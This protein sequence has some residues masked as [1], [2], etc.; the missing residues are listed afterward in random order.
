[1]RRYKP[2]GRSP[3]EI[4]EVVI[5]TGRNGH[6]CLLDPA[7]PYWIR[8]PPEMELLG[9]SVSLGDRVEHTAQEHSSRRMPLSALPKWAKD[10][11]R[12]VLK[13][14]PRSSTDTGDSAADRE[15]GSCL[16]GLYVEITGECNLRC[17][18][19][20]N[21]SGRA[22]RE[23]EMPTETLKRVIVEATSLGASRITFSGGE[24][25]LR[26]DL[27]LLLEWAEECGISAFVVTNGTTISHE[28]ASMLDRFT[29]GVQVS[30]DGATARAHDA[31]RGK[32]AYRLMRHGLD[33]LLDRG[34]GP[35]LKLATC[36]TRENLDELGDIANMALELGIPHVAFIPLHRQ[37]R[38]IA[39]WE[40]LALKPKN[41]VRAAK[42]LLS[43]S[44]QLQGQLFVENPWVTGVVR[45]LLLGGRA[46]SF[47]CTVGREPRI[48]SKGQVYP[49]AF[50]D[51]REYVMGNVI[52][53][54]LV[55]A[56][57]SPLVAEL[58]RA[59]ELRPALVCG[60]EGRMCDWREYCGGGCM[61]S[62]Y[63]TYG[64]IW[65]KSGECEVRAEVYRE[66]L[67]QLTAG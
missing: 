44:Q 52:G 48:D 28:S 43:L 4:R 11:L 47:N 6:R 8:I 35:R 63:R 58:R 64:T 53:G 59:V 57:S 32:G 16:D 5:L 14:M 9:D 18:H 45:T 13:R 42:T 31:I 37:G 62:A 65:A 27:P 40:R 54:S 3:S 66:V 1:M 24:P 38:T 50:F 19:C 20:Y 7:I 21:S 49:C 12:D 51:G 22:S 26:Q 67:G 61:A 15:L 41:E 33:C 2:Y 39:D 17:I 10:T 60:Q 56:L 25:L 34:L 36:I 46:L 55:Q 23:S 30:V 29:S